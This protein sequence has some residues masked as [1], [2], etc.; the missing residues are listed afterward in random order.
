MIILLSGPVYRWRDDGWHPIGNGPRFVYGGL[1]ALWLAAVVA[2]SVLIPGTISQDWAKSAGADKP[3]VQTSQEATTATTSKPSQPPQPEPAPAADGPNIRITGEETRY[4]QALVLTADDDA[5]FTMERLVFNGR[6]NEK[7]CDLP[8]YGLSA[9]STDMSNE[10]A[11]MQSAY[12]TQLP[13]KMKRGDRAVFFSGCGA[14]R[15]LDIYTDQGVK[16]MKAED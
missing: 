8:K 1:L 15:T 3:T 13:A 6:E 5:P 14:V 10:A 11:S 9:E 2:R 12:G 16:H 7:N 4:G